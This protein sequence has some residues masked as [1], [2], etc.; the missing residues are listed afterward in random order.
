M[1]IWLF[2]G[3]VKILVKL[4]NICTNYL[5]MCKVYTDVRG[6]NRCSPLPLIIHSLMLVKLVD[7]LHVQVENHGITIKLQHSVCK[8]VCVHVVPKNSCLSVCQLSNYNTVNT[9]YLVRSNKVDIKLYNFIFQCF[10]GNVR[11]ILY[12][13][14]TI[15]GQHLPFCTYR[16]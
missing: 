3:I 14:K 2:F 6:T 1:L 11:C 12:G 8:N 5:D 13:K 7:Y 16:M 9:F 15:R 4:A 10:D